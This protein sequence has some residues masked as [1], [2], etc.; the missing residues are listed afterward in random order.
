MWRRG[1]GLFLTMVF[2]AAVSAYSAEVKIGFVDLQRVLSE[3]KR[4]QE[5]KAKI[6]ARGNELDKQFQQMQKEVQALK[7]EIDKKGKLLSANAL[8]EKQR[9]YEQ[10]LK[11]LE[12]F[13]QNSRQELQEMEREAVAQILKD[14]EKVISDIG[15]REGYTVILEKQRS[16]ILFAPDEIDLTDRVIKALDAQR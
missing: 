2:L 7:E 10:K 1:I 4:G 13:V 6:E 11:Q 9:E 5:A 15:K 16:F 12:T 3:S 14:A 8:K